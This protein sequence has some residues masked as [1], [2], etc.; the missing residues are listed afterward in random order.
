M[1]RCGFDW[2]EASRFARCTSSEDFPP[3]PE[4]GVSAGKAAPVIDVPVLSALSTSTTKVVPTDAPQDGSG[5]RHSSDRML[6]GS[7]TRRAR[8][9]TPPSA[10]MLADAAVKDERE[11]TQHV[12]GSSLRIGSPHLP[13]YPSTTSAQTVAVGS[14]R[15]WVSQEGLPDDFKKIRQ[16]VPYACS[17][18]NIGI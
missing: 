2:Q 10:L 9:S 5:G 15:Q 16:D 7:I 14:K 12:H 18:L 17:H 3:L 11:V 13:L 4:D 1:P 8:T 6:Y